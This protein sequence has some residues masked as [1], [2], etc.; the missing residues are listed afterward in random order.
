MISIILPIAQNESKEKIKRCLNSLVSQTYQDFEVIIVTFPKIAKTFFPLFKKYSFVKKILTGSWNKSAARNMGA[1]KAQ[2]NYLLH[3]DADMLSSPN[4]LSEL[5]QKARKKEEAVIIPH[6]VAENVNFW[7][8]CRALEAK[9]ILGDPILETPIFLKKSLFQKVGGFEE[10]L[11]PLDDW[12]L[13]LALK[14]QGVKFTRSQAKINLLVSPTLKDSFW[15]MFERGQALPHLEEKYPDLPQIKIGHKTKIYRKNWPILLSSSLCALGLFFLKMI[16]LIAFS[17]GKRHPRDPYSLAKTA[18]SFEKKRLGSNF[19]RYKHFVECQVLLSL[20]EVNPEKILEVGCGTGRMTKEL[21]KRGYRVTPLDPSEAMLKQFP[22]GLPRPIK[23]S[24]GNLPF[25][26]NQF[27]TVLALRVIWHLPFEEQA[28]VTSEMRRVTSQFVILD[29]ANKK[30]FLAKLLIGPN[31]YPL[32]LPEFLSFSQKKGLKLKTLIP[33]D[34]SL[35][36]WL[37]LLPWSIAEK[38]FPLLYQFDLLLAKF[39]PPGRY[40]LQLKKLI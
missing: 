10:K 34:V 23:A 18:T 11:D 32:I 26:E 37:N 16:D 9:L 20:L 7:G 31:T 6:Q 27:K 30:R 17:W 22:K 29:I 12:G 1:K 19:T 40:L 8:R 14:K 4:L 2:G 5:D 28:K 21:V 3:L 38:F 13:H 35:P 33:L 39:I 24:G 36:L 15:R 25:K